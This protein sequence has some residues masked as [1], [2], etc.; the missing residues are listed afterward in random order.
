MDVNSRDPLQNILPFRIRGV[1]AGRFD[2]SGNFGI[3]TRTPT[4]RLDISGA[5]RVTASSAAATALTTTGRVGVNMA[6]PTADLDVSGG[7]RITAASATATALTTTG[8]VGVNTASPTV[9]LDVSGNAKIGDVRIGVTPLYEFT[10]HTF[11]NAGLTGSTG[12]TLPV[13]RSAYSTVPGASWTQDTTNNYLN[14]TTQGIQ[15][16]RVPVTGSYTIRAVGAGRIDSGN[17]MDATITTTL[18]KG[19]V[20][21]ILVGQFAIS[22]GAQGGHGG[23][24]VVRGTQEPIIVAGGGGGRGSSTVADTFSNATAT[25]NGQSPG[26]G[27]VG[28]SNGG[29]GTVPTAYNTSFSGGGGG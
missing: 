28:G 10:S 12:P 4:T 20:I 24:F 15:L 21:R 6:T 23:T 22:G 27:G 5:A 7:S 26:G 11:T 14:M 13:V 1:E 18:I 8:R 9:T 3:G 2:T 29:G 17:G 19:E 16:W 25:T